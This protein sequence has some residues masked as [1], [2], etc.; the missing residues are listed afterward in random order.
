MKK[1]ETAKTLYKLIHFEVL[2]L[3]STRSYMC[4]KLLTYPVLCVYFRDYLFNA[5]QTM[6]CVRRKADWA[7]QWIDDKQS[8]FGKEDMTFKTSRGTS[9][10]SGVS[11]SFDTDFLP[12]RGATCGFCSSG[13]HLLLWVIR[14]HLL[15][16]KER[17]NA[18]PH[19]LQRAD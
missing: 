16:K 18:W 17:P 15:A 3:I 13:G 14:C 8:T 19:V 1:C 2:Y 9:F 6:P 12:F 5:T 11:R 4:P 7:L 10:S